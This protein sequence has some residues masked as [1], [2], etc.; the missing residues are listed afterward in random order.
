M[1]LIATLNDG[2]CPGILGDLLVSGNE[3]SDTVP[4]IPL[5]GD[6]TNVF[7][8]GSE[9]SI[10]G[11]RQK[12][13]V[14]AGNC[15]IAWSGVYV[16]A[17]SI[18][19]E[20]RELASQSSLTLQ[21][22]QQYFSNLDSTV[23][24]EVSFVGLLQDDNA[25]HQFFYNAETAESSMFGRMNAAGSGGAPFLSLAGGLEPRAAKIS[26]R[27][28]NSLERTVSS[29]LMA[30]G[31]MLQAELSSQRNLLHYF[32]GGYELATFVDGRFAKVG[33]I[34]FI[35][36]HA[37]V[38]EDGVGLGP[39]AAFKQD[40]SNDI[41]LIHALRIQPARGVHDAPSVEDSKYVVSPVDQNI[42]QAQ[43]RAL[44]WPGLNSTFTCHV[45]LIPVADS[46]AVFTRIDYSADRTP[47]GIQFISTEAHVAVGVDPNFVRKLAE[48]IRAGYRPQ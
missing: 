16:F 35:F 1:T 3:R 22:I 33:D 4:N 7:P 26:G 25:F 46:F 29:M 34:M 40:Y 9:Y 23:G 48:S 36:W 30:T 32:G 5:V 19:R 41:L 43:A 11:L 27:D 37:E 47:K 14:I 39:R 12:V 18:V 6:V 20:L 28:I 13:I 17:R 45:V 42:D 2:K 38:G 8:I 21:T 31:I 10:V 15:V 44:Q 24:N